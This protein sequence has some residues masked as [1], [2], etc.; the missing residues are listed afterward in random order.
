MPKHKSADFEYAILH[1]DWRTKI[2]MTGS[3]KKSLTIGREPGSGLVIGLSG[4]YVS[5]KAVQLSNALRHI[6]P[7]E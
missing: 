2:R 5:S 6:F 4:T 1:Q 3:L 7:G